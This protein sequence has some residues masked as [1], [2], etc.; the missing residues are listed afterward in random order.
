M[1]P[2]AVVAALAMP[3]SAQTEAKEKPAMYS[4]VSD[5][6]IP[7]AQW[8]DMDKSNAAD[9]P[10][11]E[12]ALAAGTLIGYGDDTTIVHQS[13]G[14]THDDWWS[15]MSMAGLMN[16]L[17]Q[18]Y[19]AGNSTLP[20]LDNATKHWDQ[21]YV[22]HYYNWKAGSW[23]GLYGHGA[24][25]HLK[26]DAPNDA[27]EVLSK[28]LF[29][30]FFEKLLADGTI[31][32]YEVDTEAIHTD[33]PNSIFVYYLCANAEGLDKVNT[34]LQAWSKGNPMGGP[35]INA[36]ID[37]STHRDILVRSNATYK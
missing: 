4:Y 13:D 17:D 35:A 2:L 29:V 5:W 27:V 19:K 16:V 30:P 7:R 21:I 18:F 20:V 32:E 34:A 25:Y 31:Y 11:L 9:L 37:F 10:I 26:A 1:C 24:E 14:I 33:N 8:G 28:S 36:M 12:K 23:K 6:A 22:S 15:A 3:L